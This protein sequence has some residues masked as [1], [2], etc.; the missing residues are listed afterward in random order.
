MTN[1]PITETQATEK[2]QLSRRRLLSTS[3]AVTTA[4]LGGVAG[5]ASANQETGRFNDSPG[6]GGESVLPAT[7]YREE[8]FEITGRTGDTATEID[9]AL[10]S[11]NNGNGGQIFLVGWYF[12]YVDDDQQRL[13]FTRSNNIDTDRTYNWSANGAKQCDDSGVVLS[14]DGLPEDFV[15]VSYRATGPQ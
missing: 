2:P 12:E 3:A 9:G 13:L 7:D 10:F 15:Q 8:T 1:N 4:L 11:C 5:M 6:R 14:G